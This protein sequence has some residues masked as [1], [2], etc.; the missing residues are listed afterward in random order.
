MVFGLRRLMTA[1]V[2]EKSGRR[3]TQMPASENCVELPQAGDLWMRR[4]LIR[5]IVP[6][7]AIP[8][9]SA[10][11]LPLGRC[12]PIFT[13]S[14]RLTGLT[15]RPCESTTTCCHFL[16]PGFGSCSA[17]FGANWRGSLIFAQLPSAIGR[18]SRSCRC[19]PKPVCIWLRF[20]PQMA[21]WT[22]PKHYFDPLLRLAI[23]RSI[24]VL[25]TSWP[26]K[27]SLKNP[28]RA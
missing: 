18:R 24:G 7:H 25:P 9:S 12:W 16:L 19:T 17:C 26:L 21:V 27:A 28:K 11:L 1:F 8:R 15:K 4:G 20:I 6:G 3:R 14:P 22:T 10:T 5:R 13:T 23:R 2:S